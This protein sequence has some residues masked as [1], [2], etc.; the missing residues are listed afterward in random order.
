MEGKKWEKTENGGK[1]R[2]EKMREKEWKKRPPGGREL[3]PVS[4]IQRFTS[5]TDRIHFNC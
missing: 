3:I 1:K 4:L 2:E 5:I